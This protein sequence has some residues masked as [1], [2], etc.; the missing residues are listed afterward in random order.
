MKQPPGETGGSGNSVAE[1]LQILQ[2]VEEQTITPEEAAR[3]LEA[4]DRSDRRRAMAQ[5]R[6]TGPRNLRIRIVEGRSNRADVDVTLP[7]GLVNTIVG[8]ANRFAPGRIPDLSALQRQID[9]GFVGTLVD[10]DN[11][12]DRVQ[13]LVEP[14]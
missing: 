1:R 6:V 7:L 12:Q 5:P 9:E 11:G 4:L 13:I 8:M 2:M 10:I 3:L 14:R